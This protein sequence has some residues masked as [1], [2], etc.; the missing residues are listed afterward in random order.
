VDLFDGSIVI[1]K[2]SPG[3]VRATLGSSSSCK[4]I[5]RGYAAASLTHVTY[6]TAQKTDYIRIVSRRTDNG[7]CQCVLQSSLVL[8]VPDG[9]SLDLRTNVGSIWVK[10]SP[11][12]LKAES[13][14][15][16][17]LFELGAPPNSTAHSISPDHLSLRGIGGDVEITSNN[18]QYAFTGAV[19][20]VPGEG[21]R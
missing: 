13:S 1:E 7:A 14:L 19:R 12:K 10:G 21:P 3:E 18:G 16:A 17:M 9:S 20:V 8:F 2:G 15:G 4:N 5:S 11:A 6:E